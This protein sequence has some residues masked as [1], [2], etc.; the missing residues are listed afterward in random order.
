LGVWSLDCYKENP[1]PFASGSLQFFCGQGIT[2]SAVTLLSDDP[3][4][5]K[6]LYQSFSMTDAKSLNRNQNKLYWK[7]LSFIPRL[8]SLLTRYGKDRFWDHVNKTAASKTIPQH[9][10]LTNGKIL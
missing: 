5:E 10:A 9:P 1:D 4:R 6:V 2:G 8:L 7:S 3:G